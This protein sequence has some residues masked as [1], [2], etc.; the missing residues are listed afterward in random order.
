MDWSVAGIVLLAIDCCLFVSMVIMVRRY[1]AQLKELLVQ[2]LHEPEVAKN[3]GLGVAS[4]MRMSALG[5]KGADAK[6]TKAE[7]RQMLGE[8]VED[9]M[10]K[11]TPMISA[12]KEFFPEFDKIIKKHPKA[13]LGLVMQF[14]PAI[15]AK[16]QSAMT[17]L[18]NQ[19]G[20][21]K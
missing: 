12:A 8:L 15:E 13:A 18:A 17:K 4:G 2:V 11:N 19:S 10:N 5:T 7:E 16:A 14:G 20:M 1:L 6:E 9:Y 21:L 3:L